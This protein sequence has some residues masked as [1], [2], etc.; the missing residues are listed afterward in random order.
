MTVGAD[1]SGSGP[2]LSSLITCLAG[3]LGAVGDLLGP[4]HREL[5]NNFVVIQF[6]F[7]V[8]MPYWQFIRS[9]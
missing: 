5:G 4:R 1:F 7:S 2:K 3:H 9:L 6:T 8:F